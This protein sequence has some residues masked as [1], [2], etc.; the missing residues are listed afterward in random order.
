MPTRTIT[1]LFCDLVGSTALLTRLGDDRGNEVRRDHLMALRDALGRHGGT[2]IKSLGDGLMVAFS[3]AADAVAAAV[4]MQ[5]SIARLARRDT[6]VS[7][8]LRVGVSIGES[9]QE[10]DDWFGTPVVEA[11]RL[12]AARPHCSPA[13]EFRATRDGRG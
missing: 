7:L 13:L 12:C 5:R 6:S 1:L 10:D 9:T 11:A 3:S 4:A 8:A 2:E